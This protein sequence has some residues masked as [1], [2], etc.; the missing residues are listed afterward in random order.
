MKQLTLLV[1]I[2]ALGACGGRDETTTADTAMGTVTPPAT[3]T[4]DTT[5]MADTTM[6]DTMMHDTT[7]MGTPRQP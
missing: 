7:T 2:V 3:G 6:R 4:M 1:A 5:R